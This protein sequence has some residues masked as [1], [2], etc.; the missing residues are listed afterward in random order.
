MDDDDPMDEAFDA[1]PA[2]STAQ[3]G[4]TDVALDVARGAAMLKDKA[5]GFTYD[6]IAARHGYSD[7][8]AARQALLRVLD[9]YTSEKA[10]HLRAI[11]NER[12]EMD[13]RALRLIIG[14]ASKSDG[15]RI[16]AI[17][18]RT[19]AAARHAR[20]NG[21]DAPL[22]VAL[23]AGVAADLADAL[24]EAESVLV[25]GEVLDSHD[26]PMEA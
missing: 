10:T 4:R 16:K 26:E 3:G 9:R 1:L 20:L 19:R 18:A 24:A 15:T 8:S 2:A 22:Q 25:R 21:L 11:E 5:L 6:E 17:D 7:R 12:Y 13:Q 23:S 14:D